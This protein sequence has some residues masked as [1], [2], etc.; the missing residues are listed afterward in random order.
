MP[1][2]QLTNQFVKSHLT[3]P[4]EKTRIEYCDQ[5]LS[6]LYIEVRR[7]TPKQG[8]YYLRYK[9][10][11]GK[12]QHHR[13]G[14]TSDMSLS[15][16]KT[17]ARRLKF[18][19]A[20]DNK[21]KLDLSAEIKSMNF[22]TYMEEKYLPY[23]V[24]HK[25]SH[26][27]DESMSRLRIIPKFGHLPLDELTRQAIQ[28][29][30]SDLHDEG[31]AP[32][33]CDHHLKLIRYALNLAVDWGYLDKNPA[34]RIQLF[35]ADNRVEKLLTDRE[36]SC[37]LDVLRTDDNRMVCMVA[38]FLLCTGARL[39]E[40]LQAKWSQIETANHL[41]RIP[42]RNS[43]SKR[44]RSVPLNQ[45]ALDIL[46]QLRTEG[47]CEYLF[48]SSKTGERMKY[49]HKVWHRI[50]AKAGLSDL[51]LHDLRHQ[52]ASFLVNS[53]R[54]LYEVQQILG[55]SSPVVTQRYAHLST[56]S[57]QE[58]ADSALLPVNSLRLKPVSI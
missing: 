50:R 8:S 43:K 25:R 54:S 18:S 22:K 32:A 11:K 13:I 51:R 42:A 20:E 1:V 53:G 41:W 56:K 6:G 23:A 30:H 3:C 5:S 44:I 49:I 38:L 29:F 12:T 47:N 15:E 48:V 17:E 57:L 34:E 19:I 40:A 39:N 24:I 52:Y 58:A 27:F 35:R 37:L 16:A 31:L 14:K 26:R 7:T 2:V 4:D 9:N 46:R 10:H 21:G 55:H 28:S 45:S 33:T 36:L